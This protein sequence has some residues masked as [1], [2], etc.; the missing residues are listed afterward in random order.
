MFFWRETITATGIR[1]GMPEP[2]RAIPIEI[3]M[4]RYEKKCSQANF[5]C[6]KFGN[7][8][9][10]PMIGIVSALGYLMVSNGSS[11]KYA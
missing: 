5:G 6:I 7:S 3:S 4:Q 8:N 1:L 10:C 9:G 11:L 2:I